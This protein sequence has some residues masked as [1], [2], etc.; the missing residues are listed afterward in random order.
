LTHS[1]DYAD[2]QLVEETARA[3]RATRA[4]RRLRT[5]LAATL[6]LLLVA[7]GTTW[8]AV[9]RQQAA[10]KASQQALF[11]AL[12]AEADKL[13][14]TNPSLAAQLDLVAYRLRPTLQRAVSLIATQ[15][16]TLST[17]L[18]GGTDRVL[19]VAISS[20]GRTVVSGPGDYGKIRLWNL[21]DSA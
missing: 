13:A 15:N 2:R 5:A 11:T 9:N 21:T 8:L 10:Q 6:A 19:S 17:S 14:A 20:D 7:G 12:S 18:D 4:R 16:A 1:R 3:D